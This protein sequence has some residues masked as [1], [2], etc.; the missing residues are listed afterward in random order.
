MRPLNFFAFSFFSV[1]FAEA[2]SEYGESKAVAMTGV[3]NNSSSL[4]KET[5]EDDFSDSEITP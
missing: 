3:T 5:D 4:K 2:S 1:V